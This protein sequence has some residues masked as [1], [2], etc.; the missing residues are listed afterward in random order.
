[1]D[2]S[3]LWTPAWTRLN[4]FGQ[5]NCLM[6]GSLATSELER[7][8]E[9]IPIGEPIHF[10]AQDTICDSISNLGFIPSLL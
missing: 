9:R 7:G 3:V 4:H 10:V 5:L 6:L 1:M 2:R 8:N